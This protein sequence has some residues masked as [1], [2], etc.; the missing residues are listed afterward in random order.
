VV[1]RTSGVVKGGFAAW[2]GV[3]GG[4]EWGNPNNALLRWRKTCSSEELKELML[5]H[6]P[7]RPQIALHITQG[8]LVQQLHKTQHNTKKVNEISVSPSQVKLE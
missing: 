6:W 2:G 5:V 4:A 1:G 7:M 8:E 3:G